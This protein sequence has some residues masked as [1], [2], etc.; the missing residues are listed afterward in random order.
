LLQEI[1]S[2]P[3]GFFKDDEFAL[4]QAKKLGAR[5]GTAG[6][7]TAYRVATYLLNMLQA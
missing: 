2:N 1:L 3:N 5:D 7:N 4:G 6:S